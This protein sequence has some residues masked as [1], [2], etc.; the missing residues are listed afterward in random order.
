[1]ALTQDKVIEQF[2]KTHGN[3]Y[4]YSKVV[5]IKS[6]HKVEIIC[7]EHGS[8]FQTPNNHKNG[9]GCIICSGKTK[10]TEEEIL[11]R[12]NMIHNK[13]ELKYSYNIPSYKNINQKIKITCLIYSEHGVFEQTISNLFSIYFVL[14]RPPTPLDFSKIVISSYFSFKLLYKLQPEKPAPII[15]IFIFYT[16]YL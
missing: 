15:A 9:Q 11:R 13:D 8:F 1:M 7:P 16:F 6:N 10:Q 12:L 3:K 5:Y 4:N 14:S 2:K